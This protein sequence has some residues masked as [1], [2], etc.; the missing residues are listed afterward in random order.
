MAPSAANPTAPAANGQ[1]AAPADDV[2]I[3]PVT[4]LS[5]MATQYISEQTLQQ[6]L[7]A[8][9]YEE[10]KDDHY[11][12]RGVQ[13]I[14]NVR[15]ALQL[16][17]KTFDTA[18][19][20]YHRFRIRFPS[21]EYNYEDVALAALFVACKSEDTI[22]KSRDI[23]CAAHN[24][25]SPHD[26]KT[27]DDKHFDAPSKFTI[28][29]ERHILETI[30]FDFRAPY[31]QKLLIKMAKK[32]VPEGERNM[33]F[34]RGE[35]STLTSSEKLLHTAYDM[36]IDI[37]KTFVPIKQTALTMVLSIVR[38]TAMLMEQSLE[39]PR[40]KTKVASRTQE[41][42][43]Y[44][45]MLDLMDLYT[46]HPRSTKVGLNY[47][48]QHLMDVKIEINKRMTAEG[49]QRY[50]AMCKKCTDQP[51]N[52]SVTPGS[53]NSPATNISGTGGTSVKRKRANSE[54]TLRFVFDAGAARQERNLA[55]TYFNDEYEE[56]EVEVE[57]E[58][59]VPPTDPRHNAGGGRGSHHGHHGGHHN[60]RHDYGYH[61]RGGRHPYHDNRHRGNRR[62]GAGMN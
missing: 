24:L 14:D 48:L 27:P 28:G 31:P 18:A 29:L 40:F 22:K 49:F 30:G 37:Y 19:I 50:N 41:A 62:G 4:G 59:K 60:N 52:R 33:K 35:W 2:P 36:S 46:T 17:I 20:Y 11:R 3:G 58:I 56:Y 13:L 21:S 38:L 8:I 61:N 43:V 47:E 32:L 12:I 6:R 10:A 23:L 44:E 26:K 34:P 5:D 54:G 51:D 45:T 1:S 16:P 39:P 53:V 25:R 15:E 42:C 55:A 57:E 9:A 7:K